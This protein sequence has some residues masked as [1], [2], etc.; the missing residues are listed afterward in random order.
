MICHCN[1][2]QLQNYLKEASLTGA[3]VVTRTCKTGGTD[4]YVIPIGESAP[5]DVKLIKKYHRAWFERIED[6]CENYGREV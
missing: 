6:H 5:K 3:R 4:L 2:C 1:F